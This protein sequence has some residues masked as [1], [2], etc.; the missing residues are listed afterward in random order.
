LSIIIWFL[1]WRVSMN[2]CHS[3]LTSIPLWTT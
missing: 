2:F 3:R 1:L